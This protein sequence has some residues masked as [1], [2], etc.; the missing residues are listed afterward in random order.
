M[1][2]K[3]IT[4]KGQNSQLDKSNDLRNRKIGA[5]KPIKVMIII[6]TILFTVFWFNKLIIFLENRNIDSIREI[7]PNIV[8]M[9]DKITYLSF[10]IIALISFISY[11]LYGRISKLLKT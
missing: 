11:V 2:Y 3:E 8:N 9:N 1:V 5:T 7:A 4:N 6:N 10:W